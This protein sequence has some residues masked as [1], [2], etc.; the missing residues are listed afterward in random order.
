MGYMSEKQLQADYLH[1]V[2]K[3]RE[4]ELLSRKRAENRIKM[5]WTA[6]GI[7]SIF[8]LWYLAA[9]YR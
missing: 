7:V 3:N 8:F 4:R 6:V 1:I 5:N 9:H 2:R